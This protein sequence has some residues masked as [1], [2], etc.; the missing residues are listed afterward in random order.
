MNEACYWCDFENLVEVSVGNHDGHDGMMVLWLFGGLGFV[1][2]CWLLAFSRLGGLA[3]LF[4]APP[5]GSRPRIGVRGKL[6]GN[7]G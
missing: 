2:G 7:D 1:L 6:R 4:P 5:L 3:P